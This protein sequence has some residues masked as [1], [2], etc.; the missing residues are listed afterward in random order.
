MSQYHVVRLDWTLTLSHVL[1]G[2]KPLHF[3]SLVSFYQAKHVIARVRE[4]SC[5]G[6]DLV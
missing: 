3:V 5:E 4:P 6:A 1:Q 2:H